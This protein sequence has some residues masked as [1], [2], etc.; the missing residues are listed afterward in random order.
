MIQC[1]NPLAQYRAYKE[2]IDAAVQRV[3]DSGRYILGDET[4]SFEGE[5]AAYLGIG[6]AVGVGSGTEAIHIALRACGIGPGDEV[7]TVSHTA[8]ATIAAIEMAGAQPVLIDIDPESYGMNPALLEKVITGRTKAILPVHL[9]GQPV[10]LDPILSIARKHSLR[11]IED[12]AQA[13]G[14]LYAGR[15]VGTLGDLGCFSFYPTKNLGG[16]GDGGMVVTDDPELARRM[17]LIREYGWAERYIS[18]IQGGN[19]RLD[20]LQAAVLRVKLRRLEATNTARME[21]AGQ[22]QAQLK[23]SSLVLPTCRSGSTH[24]YHLYVVRARR[25]DAMQACLKTH[26]IGAL[27]HYPVPVHLQPA[28]LGRLQGCESLQE[29][30]RASKEILS[31]P[32]YPE[33]SRQEQQRVIDAVLVG[34]NE[35]LGGR[36]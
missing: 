27:I 33:L 31:L 7:I 25:R 3:L 2:E 15:R 10:D 32:M 19:S 8:V 36:A 20:E 21:L 22:Y 29:T 1:S 4:R 6:H 17:A 35:P 14:A 24:V 18:S 13:H 26:G 28:Y 30:E 5:F 34:T 11:V 9:Y 23:S 12:C 16:F